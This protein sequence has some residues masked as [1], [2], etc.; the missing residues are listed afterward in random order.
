MSGKHIL[1]R[2]L[3]LN[4]L[5]LIVLTVDVNSA[6]AISK[7]ESNSS[8]SL[9]VESIGGA[10]AST[11]LHF[12]F[13]HSAV[14]IPSFDILSPNKAAYSI[15]A[16]DNTAP[17]LDPIGS[18]TVDEITELSFTASASD[19][20]LTDTLTF[21]LDPGAP[22]GA[23]ITSDGQF[24][25]T[26]SEAQGP[27]V[28]QAT[29]RVTDDGSPPLDDFETITI[30]VNEVNLP[31]VLNSIGDKLINELTLLSF[32]ASASDADNPTNT[33]TY[34]LDPG[35]PP[36]ASITPGGQFTWTP[37]ETQGP[38]IYPI[39]VRVTDNGSPNLNDSEL[40][41]ITVN[42]VNLPPVLNSIGNKIVD[43][44]TLLSFIA[45]ATDVD[46]PTNTLTYSLDPGAPTGASITS[47]GQFTWTPT[48]TQGPGIYPVTV[49][50]TDNGSPNLNDSEL[51]NIT[52]NDSPNVNFNTAAQSRLENLSPMT[53]TVQL[54]AP[55]S[56][57]VIV[58]FGVT[59]TATLTTDFSVSP[60]NQVT[61]PAGSTSA[62][63][64]INMVNDSLYENNETVIITMG[65]PTNANKGAVNVS[66]ATIN[67]DDPLP[68]VNF[69]PVAQSQVEDIASMTIAAQIATASGLDTIVPF[70]V[71][72]TASPSADYT[73]TS[74][75]ITIPAGSTSANITINVVDD[76]TDEIDET[77]IVTMDTP[78]Y[79][80]QGTIIVSTATILDNDDIPSVSFSTATSSESE[81]IGTIIISAQLSSTSGLAV[82]V[83]FSFSGTAALTSDFTITS[84]PI[85]IPAGSPS[86]D[87]TITVVDDLIDENN[88]TIV[89][90][91]GTPTNANQG[92]TTASTVTILDNDLPPIV[93]F[94]DDFQD[95]NLGSI[96]IFAELNALSGMDVTVPF[97]VSGGT[98]TITDD[99]TIST[100]PIIIP[101]G[102][103]SVSKTITIID[104]LLYEND[105]TIILSMGTPT[106]AS[107]GTATTAT[108]TI[109]DNE[110]LKGLGDNY[111]IEHSHTLDVSAPGVLSNDPIASNVSIS[112]HVVAGPSHGSL[113]LNNNGSFKYTPA[114]AYVGPD[115][116]QY[117]IRNTANNDL[118]SPIIVTINV[119][120][121]TNPRVRWEKPVENG[122]QYEVRCEDILL[123]VDASDDINVDYVVLSY[124][125]YV[126]KKDVTIDVVYNPPYSSIFNT[127]VL[128]PEFNQINAVAFD[129][130][131]NDSGYPAFIWLYRYAFT[132]YLPTLN[133]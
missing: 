42:E 34:S 123:D 121:P 70:S 94:V 84:S 30:T 9:H 107:Q 80:T 56:L 109:M 128:N 74:S 63:I 22:P 77:V 102:S 99:Y 64:T 67:N 130:S 28:Y 49:R 53:L 60:T 54:D 17:S 120:D 69:T 57:N 124:Y 5:T 98:A 18:K 61:I 35:A 105:E 100:T 113:T 2:L 106:N 116:F 8:Q 4:L 71:S 29:I 104:D 62:L 33:L 14:N 103:L 76:L 1:S 13:P 85:T 52:V 112:L 55:S 47:G 15:L 10:N 65:T 95:E 81:G 36:G 40:S 96:L 48:E 11:S 86:A 31:P 75:P 126:K 101:A 7:T 122:M 68:S 19:V 24:T 97:S 25:W 6:S 87:I 91:M 82:S 72:G 118:S 20:D 50:V 133:K 108:A 79:A 39:T 119:Y 27:G 16:P 115:S 90:T 66:T 21:S 44:L 51:I 32:T 131:G 46:N 58:P 83:P 26:P 38:G 114:P 110:V 37:T 59:G 12:V 89:I 111:D 93:N 127:C 78:T 23:G 92:I 3:V 41:N 88:E 73:I 45:S 125:D 129:S 132:V 43:E 117:T